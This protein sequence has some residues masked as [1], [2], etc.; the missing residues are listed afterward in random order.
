MFDEA[1]IASARSLLA[2]LVFLSASAARAGECRLPIPFHTQGETRVVDPST[3]TV[4]SDWTS[5]SI[6]FDGDEVM[7]RWPANS[8]QHWNRFT[9]ERC[10]A[11]G[12]DEVEMHYRSSNADR[13]GDKNRLDILRSRAR[14][15]HDTPSLKLRFEGTALV[16]LEGFRFSSD[17][18]LGDLALARLVGG[19]EEEDG[20][21]VRYEVR[22]DEDDDSGEA[23]SDDGEPETTTNEPEEPPPTPTVPEERLPREEETI[24]QYID[25]IVNEKKP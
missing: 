15:R 4:R 17:P 11:I 19:D 5:W 12:K 7:V 14:S 1:A 8:H 18:H 22:T 6:D 20:A 23:E 25:R 3:R 16:R 13:A 9:I 24:D 2:A 21:K 10:V